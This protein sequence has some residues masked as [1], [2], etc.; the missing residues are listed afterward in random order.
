MR[1]MTD[2]QIKGNIRKNGQYLDQ[3][4]GKKG[5]SSVISEEE[6]DRRKKITDDEAQ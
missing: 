4:G 3:F 6:F 1:F 5:R 2:R